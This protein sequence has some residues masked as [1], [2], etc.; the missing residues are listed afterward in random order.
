MR[1]KNLGNCK[2][3]GKLVTNLNGFY[4]FCKE[5]YVKLHK[6]ECERKHD[7]ILQGTN[8]KLLESIRL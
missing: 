7:L 3:C 2:I 6:G 8:H 1:V 5:P 4:R